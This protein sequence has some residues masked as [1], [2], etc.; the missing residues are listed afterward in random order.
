MQDGHFER[1]MG[2][3]EK[4]FPNLSRSDIPAAAQNNVAEWDSLAQVT[5][6]SLVREEFG[7]DI[8]FEEFEDATSFAAILELVSVRNAG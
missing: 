5:I 8:D 3:F 2:C 6:L 1:L 7:V 4:V